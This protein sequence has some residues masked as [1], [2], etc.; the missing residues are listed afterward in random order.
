[1]PG[2]TQDGSKILAQEYGSGA[3]PFGERPL[4]TLRHYGEEEIVEANKKRTAFLMFFCSY[5][6]KFARVAYVLLFSCQ[7]IYPTRDIHVLM[8]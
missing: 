8:S 2:M 6:S 1:M 4:L 5:V 7:K 3:N